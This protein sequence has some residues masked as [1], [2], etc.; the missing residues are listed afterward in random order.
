M[1][2]GI[3]EDYTYLD[4]AA[5]APLCEEA[6]DAM[7]TYLVAGPASSLNDA[8]ANSLHTPGRTAFAA[9][10]NARKTVAAA[11]GA[12]R[13]AEVIFTGG[14][15]ESDNAALFGMAHAAVQKRIQE[16]RAPVR[17]RIVTTRLEHEAVLKC[18]ARLEQQGFDIA[19]AA[20][21]RHGF[22][23][24]ES[25]ERVMDD[26]TVLVSVLMANAEVGSIQPIAELARAAHSRGALFHTDAVQALGKV[27]LDVSDLGVDAATFSA[28]KI[29]GPK[30]IGALYLKARTPF[31][32]YLIGG[33]QESGRRSGT[34]NVC[35]AAGFA[36]ACEV[37]VK[38]QREES[39]RQRELRDRLYSLVSEMPRVSA[40]ISIEPGD[41]RYLPNIVHV[42]VEGMESETLV[43]RLD[44]MGFGVSGGSACSS[45]S[46]EPSHVLTAIGI[47]ADRAYGA[48]RVSF[49]RYTQASD[50]E[51][52][53][54]AL[55]QCLAQ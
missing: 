11:I 29:C 16:G 43:L 21:D 12:A 27:P 37:A 26:D 25:L 40:T 51:R 10:E 54:Q 24:A 31:D 47:D 15:T 4:W 14:A 41:E 1:D 50:I 23:S 3:A 6:L 5:T 19:Y 30:G 52:F 55:V 32:S 48:L 2:G 18:A 20:C 33:G 49:G 36:A 45:R 34:Q 42:L 46:L 22:V 17:P 53:A 39:A 13:P 44:S 28:H 9:L 8:N 38:M 7:R 35:A